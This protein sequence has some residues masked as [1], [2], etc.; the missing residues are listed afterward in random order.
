[1]KE[2]LYY[3]GKHVILRPRKKLGK[4]QLTQDAGHRWW[5]EIPEGVSG[6]DAEAFLCAY[7][8]AEAGAG[9]SADE[10]QE[11]NAYWSI[12]LGIIP[13]TLS[14]TVCPRFWGQANWEAGEI[15]LNRLLLDMPKECAE[16]VLLHELCHFRIR[17][18]NSAF[19]AMLASWM[20]DWAAREGRLRGLAA[21]KERK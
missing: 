15:R 18:H 13:P 20:P 4:M 5:L 1:M 16:V 7:E 10:L 14:W 9:I 19:W 8:H 2:R 21:G 11:I 12:R 6:A 3:R 17:E